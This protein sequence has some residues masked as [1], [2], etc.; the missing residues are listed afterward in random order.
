[1][2]A[3]EIISVLRAIDEWLYN[4]ASYDDHDGC[5]E[6]EDVIPYNTVVAIRKERRRRETLI[7]DLKRLHGVNYDSVRAAERLREEYE[8]ERLAN[9]FNATPDEFTRRGR[10]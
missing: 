8:N 7:K 9:E 4:V 6:L 1:M 10:P 2:T 3:T 5:F